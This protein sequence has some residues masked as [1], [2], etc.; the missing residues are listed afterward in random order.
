MRFHGRTGIVGRKGI[1]GRNGHRGRTGIVRRTS[2]VANQRL[3]HRGSARLSAGRIGHA[4]G[5]GF[6]RCGMDFPE[7]TFFVTS[8]TAQRRLFFRSERAAMMFLD[9]LFAYRAR[10]IFRIYEFVVMGDHVHCFMKETASRVEIWKR[11][12][13]HKAVRKPA[14]NELHAAL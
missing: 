9:S 11:S 8:V 6:S 7:R 4:R 14:F 10:G 13:L 3:Q 1:V 12:F 5:G 2:I